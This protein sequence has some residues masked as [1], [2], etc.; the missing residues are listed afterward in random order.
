MST[1]ILMPCGDHC[2]LVVA[3]TSESRSDKGKKVPPRSLNLAIIP[4]DTI[5]AIQLAMDGSEPSSRA[6]SP[7][8]PP[9]ACTSDPPI[10]GKTPPP[11]D[12]ASPPVDTVP[13]GTPT[14]PYDSPASDAS[15]ETTR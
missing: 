9:N 7:S 4:G 2:V 11:P 5:H 6:S 12:A 1:C 15:A 14:V 10:P 13:Y 3:S 8:S